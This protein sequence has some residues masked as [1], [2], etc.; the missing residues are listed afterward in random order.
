MKEPEFDYENYKFQIAK[1][2]FELISSGDDSSCYNTTQL[3]ITELGDHFKSAMRLIPLQEA[4]IFESLGGSDNEILNLYILLKNE[5]LFNGSFPD[6][7]ESFG[8]SLSRVEND[9]KNEYLNQYLIKLFKD[10]RILI[11]DVPP[12]NLRHNSKKDYDRIEKT[13]AE[14]YSRNTVKRKP[15]SL[16]F[17]ALFFN[18]LY[19]LEDLIDPTVLTWDKTFQEFRKEFQPKN[20]NFRYWHLFTPGK[21]L[22]HIS[23]L[24]FKINGGAISKEILSMIETEFEVVKSVR[25]LSDVL[26]VI[27][28][29][30]SARGINLSTGLADIR[31]TYIYQ[32][33]QDKKEKIVSEEILPV[34]NVI[35][36][37]VDYYSMSKGEFGFTDFT[38]SL[39]FDFVIDKLLT[40]VRGEK[41][42]YLKHFKLSDNYTKEF[43]KIIIEVK[44]L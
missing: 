37:L 42:H 34:D 9:D 30:K 35:S 2:L 22:D 24:K 28:D 41:D 44:N 10:N 23:L 40:L 27:I 17:D 12:Y 3:Y 14:I 15:R 4:G 1:E 26:T 5:E 7:L 16:K 19:T 6:Y 13:L 33:N 29:L 43:D 11:D 21:F 20:P 8:V 32:I 25:R 18:H 31:D 38:E 36:N 39:K